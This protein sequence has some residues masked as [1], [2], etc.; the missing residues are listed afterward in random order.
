MGL[1]LTMVGKIKFFTVASCCKSDAVQPT[2]AGSESQI[3]Y[4]KA[5]DAP[6]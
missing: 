4:K 3:Q 2:L 5:N 1:L 6:T